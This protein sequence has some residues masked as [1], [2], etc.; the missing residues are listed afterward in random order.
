MISDI[1]VCGDSFTVLVVCMCRLDTAS[2]LG[3][4]QVEIIKANM[5]TEI[6]N[7]V[8]TAKAI[9]KPYKFQKSLVRNENLGVLE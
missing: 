2:T 7:T 6:S 5:C 1:F 9:N 4:M 3:R 8:H